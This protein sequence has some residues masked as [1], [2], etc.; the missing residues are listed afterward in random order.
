MT[1]S[2]AIFPFPIL[3]TF[4]RFSATKC[5][6]N[7]DASCDSAVMTRTADPFAWARR[8]REVDGVEAAEM[9]LQRRHPSGRTTGEKKERERE[10]RIDHCHDPPKQG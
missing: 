5:R 1:A 4:V 3:S 7:G 6:I 10:R 2:F 8:G 9:H